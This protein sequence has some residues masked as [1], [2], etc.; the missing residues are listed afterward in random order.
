MSSSSVDLPQP[1]GPTTAKNSPLPDVEVDRADRMQGRRR[2]PRH[3]GL[4]DVREPDLRS[5]QVRGY[6][7][8]ACRSG[9]RNRVSMILL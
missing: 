9:G 1:D 4:A 3:E 5:Q 7:L 2:A 6:C 8:I